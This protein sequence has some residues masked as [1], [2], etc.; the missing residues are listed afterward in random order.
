MEL[1][2]EIIILQLMERRLL[3]VFFLLCCP[4][5]MAQDGNFALGARNNGLAGT[6]LTLTDGWSLFNNIGGLG[7]L[8][9]DE[10]MA[11]YQNRYALQAF[12]VIGLGYA[13][14]GKSVNFGT[15]LFRYGDDTYNQQRLGLFVGN[16]FQL[17][18]LGVGASL[19]QYSIV[20][21]GIR[22]L[23]VLDFG[24][25][26]QL[27]PKIHVGA[28]IFNINGARINTSEPVPVLMKAGISFRPIEGL[29]LNMEIEKDIS[30]PQNFKCGIEYH[31]NKWVD[32][33]TGFSTYP[34][35]AAFGFD[36]RSMNMVYSYAYRTLPILAG[37]HEWSLSL[38]I[39]RE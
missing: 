8:K 15:S 25:I 19:L 4:A 3:P 22:R 38:P 32:I 13:H 10:I 14:K 6:S 5:L 33:R 27:T 29:M 11:S 2:K 12:S 35:S 1:W 17:V 37:I 21:L 28:Y 24:G 9:Q 36:I 18:S 23:P 7:A 30:Y 26:A 34:Q 20:G 39:N 16:T 31:L